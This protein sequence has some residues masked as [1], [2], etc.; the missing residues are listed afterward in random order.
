ALS[1]YQAR[2]LAAGLGL[3]QVNCH[4]D[5]LQWR[6]QRRFLG[7]AAAVALLTSHLAAK[8]RGEADAAEPSSI[9]SH[10]QAHDAAAWD[11]L[12]ELLER[13]A[14]HPAVRLLPAAEVFAAASA[15]MSGQP[16]AEGRS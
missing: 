13:L 6:P 16:A 9:L 11:F 14:R 10:H 12:A 7:T 1:T 2:R 3:A 5:I 4:L 8:R 15:G